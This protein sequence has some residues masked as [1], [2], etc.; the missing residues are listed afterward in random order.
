MSKSGSRY[1]RRSNWFKIHCLLQ[2]QQQQQH[3]QQQQQLQQ[4]QQLTQRSAL[5]I[6]S[7]PRTKDDAMMLGLE[8]YTKTISPSIS[9]PESQNSDS[10]VEV[11]EKRAAA[12]YA[13]FRSLHLPTTELSAISKEMMSLPLGFH[14]G[15][16]PLLPPT[17][18]P[19][20]SL[21]M[22][23][24]YHLYTT[25]PA[26]P[27]VPSP[28]AMR[29]P[30]A[31]DDSVNNNNNKNTTNNNSVSTEETSNKRFYLDAVLK[32][33]RTLASPI[34]RLSPFSSRKST[35]GSAANT[36]S[37]SPD[38]EDEPIPE[39]DNPI[40]LSMKALNDRRSISD[41]DDEEEVIDMR[42]SDC[43][44]PPL[45]RRAPMDLTTRA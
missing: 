39:Q 29:T 43:D 38:R 16:M 37:T 35:T 17:L 5:N 14:F 27:L 32:S 20:P 3:Q 42:N 44:S 9:S 21:A 19:P 18:M 4:A 6:T 25:P 36:P 24:P 31:H 11:S 26:A 10:S 7:T 2:E 40:D 8:E 45:K 34:N 1:G 41:D 23:S 33:Q 30:S 15:G 28:P 22:F 12:A 13:G